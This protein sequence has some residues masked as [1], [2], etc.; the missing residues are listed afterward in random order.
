[1]TFPQTTAIFLVVM[2]CVGW[3]NARTVRLPQSVAL[4]GAGITIGALLFLAQTLIGPFWGFNSVKT[5]IARLDF[6]K[7]VLGYP[8]SNGDRD[9]PP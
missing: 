7:T 2:A 5:E 8:F 6:P 4:L 1:M 9:R 3:F